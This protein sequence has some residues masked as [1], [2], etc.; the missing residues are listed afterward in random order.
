MKVFLIDPV[1]ETIEP[2]DCDGSPEA[3][4]GLIGFPTLDS[5][6]IGS[7]GDRLHFDEECFL[8][9]DAVVGR[10][11]LD[12]LAPVSGRG[13]VTGRVGPDGRVGEPA[14]ELAALQARVRFR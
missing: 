14:I 4:R 3:L 1:R 9:G 13:V 8:R 5:D 10:F 6:E 2:V 12:W 7:G 11:Q